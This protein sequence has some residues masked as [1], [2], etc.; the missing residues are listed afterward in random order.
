[1]VEDC[2]HLL[3]ETEAGIET[4][5]PETSDGQDEGPASEP[6]QLGPIT[7]RIAGALRSPDG[8]SETPP[9]HG[10]T[11][12]DDRHVAGKKHVGE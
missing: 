8:E 1:M 5:P 6:S 3:L 9:L 10:T 4:G 7:R 2:F 11:K 12:E